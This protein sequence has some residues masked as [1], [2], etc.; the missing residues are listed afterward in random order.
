MCAQS[1]SC[2]THV[3]KIWLLSLPVLCFLGVTV[4]AHT[5]QAGALLEGWWSE[6][7]F[8]PETSANISRCACMLSR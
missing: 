7:A 1:L 6:E 5:V 8:F 4:S 3:T 2:L